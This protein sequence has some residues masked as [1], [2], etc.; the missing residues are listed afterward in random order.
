M[1]EPSWTRDGE[2]DQTLEENWLFRL[3]RERFRSRATGR[4]HDFYVIHLADVVNVI[5]LTPQRQVVLVRQFRAGSG[6]DSLET[7]GGLLEPG[8]DPATAG[9]RELLEETGYAGDPPRT[10]GTTWANP[11][12][13]TSRLTTVLITRARRVAPPSPDAGEEVA[14]E[15]VPARQVPALIRDGK[16]ENGQVVQGLLT[17]L[18]A[19]LPDSPL[20]PD[21][22]EAARRFGLRIGALMWGIALV[23]LALGLVRHL[24]LVPVVAIAA[25]I[26]FPGAIA[27]TFVW[28][29]P[30]PRAILLRREGQAPRH[31]VLRLLAIVGL[32]TVGFLLVLGF[33]FR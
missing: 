30:P 10:L 6:R 8:E 15:L 4:A 9:A 22:P 17:W 14:L 32:C 2:G 1:P 25:A 20:S 23:G 21:D 13:M 7:P 27:L 24:G 28:L 19:E 33:A 29:D 3:R 11:S 31:A 5:A 26:V 18:V 12:L 16:I